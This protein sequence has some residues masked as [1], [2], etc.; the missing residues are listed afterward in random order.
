MVMATIGIDFQRYN[1]IADGVYSAVFATADEN[2]AFSDIN[3]QLAKITNGKF[4][5]VPHTVV[6]YAK[7]GYKRLHRGIILANRES[8]QYTEE[9]VKGMSLVTANVFVDEDDNVWNVVGD[10][11]TK[12]I[13]QVSSTDFDA[14]LN[15]KIRRSQITA[16]SNLTTESPFIEGDYAMIY[17]PA[18]DS[19]KYGFL[20]NDGKSPRIYKR[21]TKTSE[22]INP[23][24]VVCS[25]PIDLDN[26]D[27]QKEVK[28]EDIDQI[29]N[30]SLAE[31]STPIS[32]YLDYM[33]VLFDGTAYFTA[34]EKALRNH[35]LA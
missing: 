19:L 8:R 20:Y 6:A 24:Q 21:N 3:R 35:A 14:I 30:L 25:T 13:V 9:N 10:G 18:S 11:D 28:K 34:L 15:E 31:S 12:R 1:K 32:R 16:S 23:F 33:R 29:N 22:K 26:S 5:F 7:I 2:Y 4:S 27:L 17:C